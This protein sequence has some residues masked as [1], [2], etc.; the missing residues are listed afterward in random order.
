MD[1][2]HS[3]VHVFLALGARALEAARV[4]GDAVHHP[5]IDADDSH[6]LRKRL[7]VCTVDLLVRV[8]S[9]ALHVH[10]QLRRRI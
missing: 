5:I 10:P 1:A 2:F 8:G 7:G 9:L 4:P 3:P 6:R